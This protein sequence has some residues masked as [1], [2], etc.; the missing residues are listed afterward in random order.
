MAVL[1]KPFI[2]LIDLYKTQD[3]N[4]QIVPV[5]EMLSE[6]NPILDDAYAVECNK[7][8]THI[9]TVRTGL[10][11]IAWGKLYQGVPYSKSGKAQVEDTTGFAESL[12]GV[13][14]RL[15]KLSGN[16][17]ALRLSEAR[18]H[19]EAMSQEIATRIFYSNTASEPETFMGL[20]P[21][22]NDLNAPNGN[23]II[24]AGGRTTDNTSIW[25]VT[26]GEDQVHLLYPKNTQAGVQREDKGEQRVTDDQNNPYYVKEELFTWHVG[27]AVKDWRYV[28]RIANISLAK[29]NDGSL[30][31]YD[32]MRK[33]FYRMHSRRVPGGKQVIYANRDVIEYLDALATNSG[34]ADSFV[35]LTHKE[36]EGEAV[37]MYRGIPIREV[38]ALLNNE[39]QV[40]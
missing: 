28:V 9:H 7:G 24:D 22:F 12:S 26:W 33:A 14:T 32:F 17:G 16:E 15:L 27:L 10:P 13:D 34:A 37:T 29:M 25:F 20:A 8:S 21:R 40:S 23:Q 39:A 19:L 36:I 30:K 11:T 2:D 6:L 31:L 38:D 35:R 3:C 5:I 4:G 18:A 1:G